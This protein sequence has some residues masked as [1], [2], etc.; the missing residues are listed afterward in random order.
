MSETRHAP[1]ENVEILQIRAAALHRPCP[2]LHAGCTRKPTEAYEC[3][4]FIPG[5]GRRML[6]PMF[7]P[8]LTG[9]YE[10]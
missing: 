5:E 4:R 1:F 8:M 10:C 2:V 3:L 6:T 9:V 7:T